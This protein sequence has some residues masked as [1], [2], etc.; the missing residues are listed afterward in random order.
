MWTRD[1]TCGDV[2]KGAWSNSFCGSNSFVL[3]RK[4]EAAK[5]GLRKWN[6]EHF[7]NLQQ[8]IK[9]EKE[10]IEEDLLNMPQGGATNSLDSTL[11]EL[12]KLCARE[13]LMW[14]KKSRIS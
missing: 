11:D 6:K 10:K 14:K 9:L 1:A 2:V 3:C 4:L 13:E 5:H 7:G 8:R 12:K